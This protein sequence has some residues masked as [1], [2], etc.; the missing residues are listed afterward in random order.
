MIY[1]TLGTM[2]LDFGRLVRAVDAIAADTPEQVV[3][4]LGMA[5]TIPAHCGWFR[6]K[7][8]EELLEWQRHARVIVAHAGIGAALDALR[9]GRP[10]VMVP[11]RKQYGEHMNDHQVDIA[12][13]VARRGWGRMILDIDELAAVVAEPPPAPANYR[14]ARAPLVAAVREMVQRVAAEK[15]R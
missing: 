10:L 7:P 5:R 1:V 13:A 3:V 9:A 8:A 14:P 11:R 15:G 4:Q 2:F 12:G 6:F